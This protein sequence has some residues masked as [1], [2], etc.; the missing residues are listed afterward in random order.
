MN[1]EQDVVVTSAIATHT[2]VIFRYREIDCITQ[3]AKNT[4]LLQ[5]GS[6]VILRRIVLLD[7]KL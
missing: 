4:Q 2:D 6:E 7:E 5:F 3:K 1:A